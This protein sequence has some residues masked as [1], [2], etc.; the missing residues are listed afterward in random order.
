MKFRF[1]GL[2][3]G[4]AVVAGAENLIFSENFAESTETILAGQN[5]WIATEGGLPGPVIYDGSLSISNFS[6]S[7]GNSVK[8]DSQQDPSIVIKQFSSQSS[9]V[10]MSC[11]FKMK[12][13]GSLNSESPVLGFVQ[14]SVSTAGDVMVR[15]NGTHFDF[16]GAKQAANSIEWSTN[17]GS[18]YELDVT[19]LLVCNYRFNPNN[20]DDNFSVWIFP[21]TGDSGVFCPTSPPSEIGIEISNGLDRNYLDAIYLVAASGS[22][23]MIIDEI[24]VGNSWNS[25]TLFDSDNDGLGDGDEVGVYGTDPLD[26][27]SD[28]DGLSDGQEVN[29]YS[30]NPL[31]ADSD[32][33]GFND[34]FEVNTGYDPTL[35]TNSPDLYS[36]I[37]SAIEFQFNAASNVSYRIEAVD[38]LATAWETVE[39]DIIGAGGVVSRLYSIQGQTNRFFRAKRN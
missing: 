37:L 36:K 10:W 18:G 17:G 12:S 11:L 23:F 1:L 30:T 5:G 28:G 31:L 15:V 39:T 27:D 25:V 4:F 22:P 9:N 29:I 19:Y 24:N 16:G 14:S 3:V 20:G 8:I 21:D 7:T 38:D 26:S 6:V 34:L 35:E 13:L 33:D 2:F 32:G